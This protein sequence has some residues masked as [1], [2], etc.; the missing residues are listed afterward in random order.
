MAAHGPDTGDP[1]QAPVVD[2]GDA[3]TGEKSESTL[4]VLI[5]F[6]AN[7]PVAVAKTW[8]D[9][10]LSRDDREPML[11]IRLR[12]LEARIR[13]SP[14]VVDCTLSLS[15]PDEPALSLMAVRS[16]DVGRRRAP[17]C[18]RTHAEQLELVVDVGCTRT[19]PPRVRAQRSTLGASISCGAAAHAGT[20]DDG[21]GGAVRTAGTAPLRTGCAPCPGHRR[22]PCPA[23]PG[24][25]WPGR[26]STR[27]RAARCAAPGR[28]RTRRC[29]AST[30]EDGRRAGWCCG[31]E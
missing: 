28:T 3:F 10:D 14:A 8:S 13:E 22:P 5:A 6:G 25:R 26:W 21:G 29:P 18:S 27:T 9:V 11:A 2:I 31:V 19:R 30:C 15:A 17:P 16:S 7:F 4:T 20:P 12:A 23:A 24:T 1:A